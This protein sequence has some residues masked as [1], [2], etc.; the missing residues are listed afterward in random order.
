MMTAGGVIGGIFSWAFGDVGPLLVWL[1]VFAVAD[2][3]VGTYAAL[4]NGLW[5][6]R[7]NFKGVAKKMAMF[8]L[9]ALAHGLDQIF[10]PLIKF[11]IFQ[12]ITICAYAAGEFG[13]IIENLESAGLGGAV[14][15]VLRNLI[16]SLNEHIEKHAE[17]KIPGKP[18][19]KQ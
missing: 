11:Q 15:P 2:F 8:L 14:P 12:S 4:R 19:E 13:S 16:H 5:S 7:E 18:K 9:V 10:E 6:S 17:T 3:F 1:V